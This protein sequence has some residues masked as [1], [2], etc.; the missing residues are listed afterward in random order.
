MTGMSENRHEWKAHGIRFEAS[1]DTVAMWLEPGRP[2]VTAVHHEA[3]VQ[4]LLRLA[5]RV[6]TLESRV[7]SLADPECC[8]G[9]R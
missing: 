1:G 4:E 3:V 8:P 6:Q 7:R 2:A 5:R 9:R